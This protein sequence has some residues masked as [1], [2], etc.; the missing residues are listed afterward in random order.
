MALDLKALDEK[1][2][3]DGLNKD[4]KAAEENGGTGEFPQLPAGHYFVKMENLELGETKDGRPMVKWMFRVID[5]AQKSDL[6]D[7]GVKGSNKDAIDFMDN[8]KPK[9]KPCMFMNRVIYGNRVT[10]SWNDGV[11]IQGV[12]TWLQKLECDFDVSFH[13]YSDFADVLL[14]VAEDIADVAML[15]HRDHAAINTLP[16]VADY[17]N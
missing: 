14:D 13:N 4:I 10:D 3:F 12:V 17:A 15:V 6:S 8:Y 2:D 7:A 11:A 1:V 16:V 5:A 9:K